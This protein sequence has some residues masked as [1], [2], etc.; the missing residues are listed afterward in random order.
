MPKV[1]AYD[2]ANP[3]NAYPRYARVDDMRKMLD[4]EESPADGN[5]LFGVVFEWCSKAVDVREAAVA[6]REAAA[7][8]MANEAANDDE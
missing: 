4:F 7:E 5:G 1:K 2:P 3:K 8:A 6:A